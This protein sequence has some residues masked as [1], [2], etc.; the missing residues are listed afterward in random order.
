MALYSIIQFA[1]C[2]I[3]NGIM[4]YYTNFEYLWVDM[5]VILPLA[6]FMSYT[7]PYDYLTKFLPSSSLLSFSV[8][9]SVVGQVFIQIIFE[10]KEFFLKLLSLN[11]FFFLDFAIFLY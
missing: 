11:N 9:A 5:F 6:I 4:S 10:V 3:L 7:K 8:L 1:G 2:T